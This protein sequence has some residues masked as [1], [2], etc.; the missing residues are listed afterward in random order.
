[1][2]L[3]DAHRQRKQVASGQVGLFGE[4]DAQAM[5]SDALP[6]IPEFSASELLSYEKEFLGFYLTTHPLEPHRAT[7]SKLDLTAV[8]EIT[9]ERVKDRVTVG[10]IVVGVKKITT[11]ASNQ[12][13]AFV[14]L[15]DVTG[16]LE[17][18]VFPKMYAKTLDLWEVDKIISV[19]GKVDEKDDRLTLLVDEARAIST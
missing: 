12:E 17:V 10:G 15:E 1:V 3:E 2:A 6:K 13:M 9:R 7:L 18:V 11:K 5:Q 14:K 4:D 19:S 8:S 16:I